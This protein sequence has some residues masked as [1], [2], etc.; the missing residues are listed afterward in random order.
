MDPVILHNA[1][2]QFEH[3][4]RSSLDQASLTVYATSGYQL[5]S[6]FGKGEFSAYNYH[7]L[8]DNPDTNVF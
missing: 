2:R 6:D 3:F 7:K 8:S 1:T 5:S 4:S